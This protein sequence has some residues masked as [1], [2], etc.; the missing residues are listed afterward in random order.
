MKKIFRLFIYS[1]IFFAGSLEAFEIAEDTQIVIRGA[2]SS[3][4]AKFAAAEVAG[5][6][7]KV[8]GIKLSTVSDKSR[9]SSQIIIGTLADVKELPASAAKLLEKADSPDAFAIVC[10]GN[11]LIIAGRDQGGELCG[12]YAFL[13]EKMG[14]RWFRAATEKDSY[15]YVPRQKRIRFDDFE[16]VRVPAFRYRMLTHSGAA[17][18][19]PFNGQTVAVRQGFQINPPWDHKRAF[20][21]KFYQE[22]CS[23]LSVSSGSHGAFYNSVPESLYKLHPEYFALQD[24]KRV[25]GKQICIS[26]LDVQHLVQKNIENIYRDFP[27]NKV[28]WLFGMLDATT[29]WC[30]CRSCR[31]LDG[32]GA[33]DHIN[34]STRFH[35]VVTKIMAEVYKKYPAAMLE[36][37]AYHTYRTIP[38]N[39]KYDPR[40][41]IYYCTHGRCYGHTLND[42]L[43]RRNVKHLQLI[44]EW[45]KIS[46]RMK[47][48][49]YANC[50]PVL[51]GCM[52]DVASKDIRFYRKLGLEGWKE[53]MLFAD[54]QF[55]PPAKEGVPD[56][57]ADRANSNWQW[58]C[59]VGK[60]LWDPEL[61][62]EEIL[63]DVES[64]YYG[65]AYPAMKKY[66]DLRRQLWN[67]SSACL[68][69]PTGDQRRERLLSVPGAKEKLLTLLQKAEKLAGNDPLLK[70]RL[71]DDRDWLERYWIKPNELFSKKAPR[72]GCIPFKRGHINVDGDPGDA[73]WC[74]AWHTSD[75]KYISGLNKRKNAVAN[76]TVCSVLADAGNLYFR[77]AARGGISYKAGKNKEYIS[78]FIIPPDSSRTGYAV[79]VNADGTIRNG[80]LPEH[81]R[82]IPNRVSAAVKHNEDGYVMEVKIPLPGIGTPEKGSLWKLHIARN[83]AGKILSLDGTALQDR[84]NYRGCTTG[85]VLLKNGTFE[86]L[87]SENIPAGWI[88]GKYGIVR[89]RISHAVKLKKG[90]Y[91]YQLLAGG[92]LAQSAA[93]RKIRVRF[94]A[95]GKGILKVYAVRYNDTANGKARYRYI[96]KFLSTKEIYKVVLS[97]KEKAYSC[98]YTIA[99]D[100]WI[101][102]RFVV[103]SGGKDSF[104]VLDDVSIARLETKNMD[105]R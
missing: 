50:T 17:G 86:T 7:E 97:E 41:L 87:T 61:D 8:S 6:I 92:E 21:E 2:K 3:A 52:E 78:F 62:P 56:Y 67:N 57:R 39:V 35:K 89:H 18:R 69:Y 91:I 31:E 105:Q 73:E 46:S 59:V 94:R 58:Y 51:Y 20:R 13:E 85:D 68:G 71:Q 5:Y 33:F 95:S 16:I 77:V 70:G 103:A 11:K 23:M 42:P 48:Y 4:A 88:G 80:G 65:K 84:A 54:A 9:A 30:E 25:K 29:G 90:G 83:I 28:A 64:K 72:D 10:S 22:R 60:L 40:A 99:P 98:E 44:K 104:A 38:E 55:W 74:R 12:A 36:V 32:K 79:V 43:C 101:G 66:H 47:L 49:E 82:N 1:I 75:F 100:E 93:A 96:R 63:A 15:E 45:R 102:L 19:I 53:E 27:V 37:W 26:N 24:G 76:K 81:Y 34:I 14:I